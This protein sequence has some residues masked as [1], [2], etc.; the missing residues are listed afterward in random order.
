MLS[1]TP[2]QRFAKHWVNNN[3]ARGFVLRDIHLKEKYAQLNINL[4]QLISLRHWFH[5]HPKV[6]RHEVET[7]RHMRGFL[8]EHAKP[9]GIITLDGAVFTAQYYNHF[10]TRDT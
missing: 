8:E 10:I 1:R 3:V 5:A 7:A 4:D 9:D 6:S 2:K